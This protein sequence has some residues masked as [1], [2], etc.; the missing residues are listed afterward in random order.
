MGHM[1][2]EN[3]DHY[4]NSCT[5]ESNQASLAALI[6]IAFYQL[7]LTSLIIHGWSHMAWPTVIG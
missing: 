2:V 1:A 6:V 5:P 3:W 4:H 7:L